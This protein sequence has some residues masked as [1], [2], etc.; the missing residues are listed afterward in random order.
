[1]KTPSLLLR[2]AVVAFAVVSAVTR[3]TR[4]DDPSHLRPAPLKTFIWG[5]AYYP[6]QGELPTLDQDAARM[7]AATNADIKDMVAAGTFREDLSR[8]QVPE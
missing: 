1:M 8:A 6:E 7:V 5:T 3:N 2:L 4:A